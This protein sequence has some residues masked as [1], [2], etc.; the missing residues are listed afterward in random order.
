MPV[1]SIGSNALANVKDVQEDLHK[2]KQSYQKIFNDL[3]KAKNTV[4]ELNQKIDLQ[5][6]AIDCCQSWIKKLTSVSAQKGAETIVRFKSNNFKEMQTSSIKN[7]FHNS[8]YQGELKEAAEL[9][10]ANGNKVSAGVA[11]K[12]LQEKID[13]F[14]S[15]LANNNN[16]LA[17]QLNKVSRLKNQS[18][19][20]DTKIHNLENSI[21]ITRKR[22]EEIKAV[23]VNFSMIYQSDAGCKAINA[24]VDRLKENASSEIKLD[25]KKV[26]KHY[27]ESKGIDVFDKASGKKIEQSIRVNC[28][29]LGDLVQKAVIDFYNPKG[30]FVKTYRGQGMTK[31]GFEKLCKQF[32]DDNNNKTKTVY[33]ADRFLSSSLDEN[34]AESF[35]N[36]SKDVIKVIF[37][38]KGFSCEVLSPGILLF[39][40]NERDLVYSP[41]ANFIVTDVTAPVKKSG[42]YRVK[43]EEVSRRA[44]AQRMPY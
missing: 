14:Q 37:E 18:Y 13:G 38:V 10:G 5:K 12:A 24:A 33:D 15:E 8:R 3:S 25:A 39:E 30:E 11:M 32:H 36:K 22:E 1:N 43:L 23:K 41:L 42:F 20:I 7:F 2:A 19:N 17:T 16:Q 28:S 27:H 35:A 40:E 4:N 44:E 9:S 21:A 29:L 34:I 26:I 6:Q 31:S